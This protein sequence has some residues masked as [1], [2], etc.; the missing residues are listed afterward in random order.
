MQNDIIK[1]QEILS[2]QADEL[3]SLSDVVYSQAKEIAELR[4]LV[5]KLQNELE[6]AKAEGSEIKPLGQENA[7]PHY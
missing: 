5:I 7:P 1:I 2:Y 6:S 4:R 3:S